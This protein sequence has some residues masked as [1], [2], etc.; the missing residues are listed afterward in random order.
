MAR[1]RDEQNPSDIIRAWIANQSN[2]EFLKNGELIDNTD[3]KIL[4]NSE[5]QRRSQEL[6]MNLY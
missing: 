4:I 3:F 2:I 1:F 5:G 6:K